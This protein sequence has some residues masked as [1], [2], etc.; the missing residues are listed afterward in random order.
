ML[1]LTAVNSVIE[2][3]SPVEH[4]GTDSYFTHKY[5]SASPGSLLVQDSFQF[6][7]VFTSLADQNKHQSH[8]FRTH[9]VF[10]C[11]LT[12]CFSNEACPACASVALNDAFLL[13]SFY[14]TKNPVQMYNLQTSLCHSTEAHDS[15]QQ[16]TTTH[17]MTTQPDRFSWKC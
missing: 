4:M 3:H 11:L 8:C 1:L 13:G 2:F 16:F 14:I 6:K 10:L 9:C 12:S 5:Y 17:C 15:P 7:F